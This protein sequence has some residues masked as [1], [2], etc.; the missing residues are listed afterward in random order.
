[1]Q[2]IQEVFNGIQGK[3]KE[4]KLLK[5]MYRDALAGAGEYKKVADEAKALRAKKK[6]IEEGVKSGM[7]ADFSK[8]EELKKDIA[9]DHEMIKDIA[10][11]QMMKGESLRIMDGNQITYEPVFSVKFRRVDEGGPG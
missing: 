1:M 11:S 10:V 7:G 6:Q 8:M 4:L 9:D 2:D 3:K 5:D